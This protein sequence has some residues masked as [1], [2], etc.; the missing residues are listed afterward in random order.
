MPKILS[1]FSNKFIKLNNTGVG[2]LDSIY[3]MTSNLLIIC[4]LV[5]KLFLLEN[6]KIISLFRQRCFGCHCIM[7]PNMK[8]T[9]V[10]MV[11]MV[12]VCLI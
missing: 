3:H 8:T 12:F 4:S 2:V 1:L 7:L 6:V 5:N 11:Y 9:T 10:T